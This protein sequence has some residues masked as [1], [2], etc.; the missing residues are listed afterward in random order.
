MGCLYLAFPFLPEPAL[1]DLYNP[2]SRLGWKNEAKDKVLT[3]FTT[4][5]DAAKRLE[6]FGQVQKDLYEDVGFLKIGNFAA[7]QGQRKGLTGIAPSPWPA[8]WNARTE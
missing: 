7:L 1:T 2:T 5:T 3:E 6:L 8:F 4:E